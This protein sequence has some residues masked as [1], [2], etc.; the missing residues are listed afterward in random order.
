MTTNV[1]ALDR[2]ARSVLGIFLILAPFVSSMP[3]F[4]SSLA[5]VISVVVGLILAGTAAISSCPLY[6]IL[7]LKTCQDC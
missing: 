3:L 2:L 7:G 5:T 6:S 1:G 4:E